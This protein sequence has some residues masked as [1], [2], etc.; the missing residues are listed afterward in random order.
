MRGRGRGGRGGRGNLTSRLRAGVPLSKLLDEDRPL[1]KPIIFVRSVHTATL[2]RQEEDI[3][4][5]LSEPV[6]ERTMITIISRCADFVLSFQANDENGHVPTADRVTQVFSGVRTETADEDSSSDD[7][8]QLEEVDFADIG[9][10]QAEVN[11]IAT[12]LQPETAP[13]ETAP[14]VADEEQFS[15]FFVDTTPTP[16]TSHVTNPI[17]PDRLE[18][19][20]G[21]QSQEDDE[22]IV[23]V[24]P[25]PRTG[26][27][28]APAVEDVATGIVEIVPSTSI[29]TGVEIS[30]ERLVDVDGTEPSSVAD[31]PIELESS[32]PSPPAFESIQFAF[33]HTPRK[34]TNQK[35]LSSGRS[36]V[37]AE[38][39]EESPTQVLA[40]L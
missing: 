21:E 16:I 22:I 37:A 29:I 24:A 5:P 26:R 31:A 10:V 27:A 40:I 34:K 38:A 11:V 9:K 6:G 39:I 19:V 4:Q 20:L 14:A 15:G 3:L 7:E 18:G 25:H 30:E 23:Y 8:E 28:P 1:L 36:A 12:T 2:F 35:D 17:I 32:V 13:T 33:D